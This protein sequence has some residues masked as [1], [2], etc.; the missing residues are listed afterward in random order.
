MKLR[1]LSLGAGVQSTTLALMAACG[2]IGPMPDVMIFADP[3]DERAATM[4]HLAWLEREITTRTNGRMQCRRTG[5]GG[6]LSDRIRLRSQAAPTRTANERF[7]SAPFFTLGKAGRVGQGKR[8]CTREF[9]IEPLERLQRDLLGYRP[10]QRIPAGA[11][12]VWIGISTD[13]VVRAGAAY[14][15]WVVHR[16]PL[17]E[18]RMSRRD[19]KAWLV[20]HGFPVPPK[21]ACFYCP[22]KSDAEWRELRDDDPE[23]WAEAVAIDR[24]VRETPGMRAR[25]FLHRS[26]VPLDQVDL[27]TAADRGQG[28]L[29]VCEAG[30]G[31]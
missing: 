23:A 13:E 15:P 26:C 17:L 1:A 11:C 18:L 27:S 28:M 14:S 8:Q 31:L 6:R 9:K 25:E 21:S 19:C 10:R 2:E 16:Y 3:G 30:C 24:L 22:Y 7:V 4:A 5:R 12:E 29:A 20:A